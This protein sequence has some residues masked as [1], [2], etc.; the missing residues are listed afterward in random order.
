MIL[1]QDKSNSDIG[2]CGNGGG[3]SSGGAF[4]CGDVEGG[5]VIVEGVVMSVMMVVFHFVFAIS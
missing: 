5:E 4:V 3:H 2:G 1:P